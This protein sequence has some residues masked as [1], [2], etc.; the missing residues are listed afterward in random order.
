MKDSSKMIKEQAELAF[1]NV[2]NRPLKS[3]EN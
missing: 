1:D 3:R 2:Y